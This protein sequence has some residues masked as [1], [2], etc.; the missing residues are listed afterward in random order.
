MSDKLQFVGGD[1]SDDVRRQRQT[2]VCRTPSEE[3]VMYESGQTT[4]I[5]I[6]PCGTC[7]AGLVEESKFCRLCGARQTLAPSSEVMNSAPNAEPKPLRPYATTRLS[8]Q[9][10]YHPVSGPLVDAV[11]AGVPAGVPPSPASSLS[12]RMLLALMAIPI[13]VM[14]ILLSPLDAYASAKIIGNRI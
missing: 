5:A 8:Q 6:K 10:L 14:I 9:K 1:R 4:T 2:E 7:G 12:R 3:W 13:W 11:V